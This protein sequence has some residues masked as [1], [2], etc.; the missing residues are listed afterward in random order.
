MTLLKSLAV[1]VS[2]KR[3][4]LLQMHQ[5]SGETI[6]NF[7]LRVKGKAVTCKFKIKCTHLHAVPAG[8]AE[9]PPNVYVDYTDEM[10]R[11]VIL[12]G[13]YDDDIR[14]DI[15]SEA[16]LDTMLVTDLVSMIEGKE[17]ARDATRLPSAGAIS[18]FKRR[19]K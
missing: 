7:L 8:Q 14:T 1:A 13:L 18:Q 4:E 19:Q 2:V 3:N 17:L 16:G 5:D 15:F 9:A 12:N 10:I 6:R 11:H